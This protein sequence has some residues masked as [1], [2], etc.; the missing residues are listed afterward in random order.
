VALGGANEREIKVTS[1]FVPPPGVRLLLTT[2][3]G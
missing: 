3:E 1:D 2:I